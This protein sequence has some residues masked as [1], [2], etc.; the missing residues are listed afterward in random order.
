[1]TRRVPYDAERTRLLEDLEAAF[2]S[3]VFA[4]AYPG[5]EPPMSVSI[6]GDTHQPAF[7]VIVWP[8]PM[9]VTNTHRTVTCPLI[10]TEF[11]LVVEVIASGPTEREATETLLAYLDCVYQ[12]CM[13]DPTLGGLVDHMHPTPYQ[14]GSGSDG[15]FGYVADMSVRVSCKRDIRPNKYIARAM[16]DKS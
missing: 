5:V 7:E 6:G 10:T 15:S 1:M 9:A 12:T 13:A 16:R 11:D 4:K 3:K 2:D 8:I 14:S